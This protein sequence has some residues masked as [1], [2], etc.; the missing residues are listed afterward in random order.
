MGLRF[1]KIARGV[2]PEEKN[3]SYHLVNLSLW[4]EI[5]NFMQ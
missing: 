3:V 4:S 2:L 5:H 1:A